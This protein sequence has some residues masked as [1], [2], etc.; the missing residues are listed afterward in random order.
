MI[1]HDDRGVPGGEGRGVGETGHRGVDVEEV[2]LFGAQDAA[3][4]ARPARVEGSV[5]QL[6]ECGE[7]VDRKGVAGPGAGAGGDD[8]RPPSGDFPQRGGQAV[9]VGLHA[10]D[11]R[12]EVRR[13]EDDGAFSAHGGS[14]PHW[15]GWLGARGCDGVCRG[16]GGLRGGAGCPGSGCR[17]R[18]C[19]AARA[20]TNAA[21]TGICAA[22]PTAD[23]AAA[24]GSAGCGGADLRVRRHRAG[25]ADRGPGARKGEA[26]RAGAAGSRRGGRRGC[27]GA[28]ATWFRGLRRCRRPIPRARDRA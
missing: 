9:H 12:R 24:A 18:R 8:D 15:S 6:G 10:A 22:A 4:P 23:A 17:G 2:G 20:V 27:R 1:S 14:C 19:G 7:P 11:V 25:G 5:G 3:D 13:R 16:S 28:R 26:L 21:S